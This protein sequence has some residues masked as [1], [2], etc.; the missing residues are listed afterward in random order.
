MDS[1]IVSSTII[2]GQ[3]GGIF[4]VQVAEELQREFSRVFV[5]KT[6]NEVDA[7][8]GEKV[9]Q[10]ASHLEDEVFKTAVSK[11]VVDGQT[12]SDS[13]GLANALK[14][15]VWETIKIPC[16]DAVTGATVNGDDVPKEGDI[17]RFENIAKASDVETLSQKVSTNKQN[18]DSITTEVEAVKNQTATNTSDIEG[19]QQTLTN[20]EHFRGYY[21]T[22]LEV[23]AIANPAEGDFS[24]NAETGTKWVFNGT[25][26]ND[27]AIPVPDQTTPLSDLTPL[28]DGTAGVGIA[29][30]AARGDHRH[31]TDTTRASVADLASYLPL[32]GG[33]L[34]G[35][36]TATEFTKT[37]SSNSYVLLGG[38]DHKPLSEFNAAGAHL[39]LA[40]G[41]I[42]GD[43]QVQGKTRVNAPLIIDATNT[44]T[45]DYDQGIRIIKSATNWATIL[46]GAPNADFG[47][48]IDGWTIAR[49]DQ[50]RFAIGQNNDAAGSLGLQITTNNNFGLGGFNDAYKLYVN[51][52]T[53]ITENIHMNGGI[54]AEGGYHS[55]NKGFSAGDAPRDIYGYF[56][57]T[58]LQ[59]IN[60]ATCFSW[61]RQGSAA[62]ALGH[63]T[64]NQIV[65][66]G[67]NF[68]KTVAPWL[69]IANYG[70]FQGSD[71]R[72]KTDIEKVDTS[73]AKNI[74]FK[75]YLKDGRKE[76]GVI[77]QEVL[78]HMPEAVTV[79]ED[80][81]DMMTVNYI[82]ILSAKC[83]Q[84]EQEIKELKQLVG[85]LK[86]LIIR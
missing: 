48:P 43:L 44:P 13:V 51:G 86:Q 41:T 53:F 74:E 68:D 7:T 72:M 32:S 16:D 46:L 22:T 60:N 39:P 38:G 30:S 52:S 70:I 14:T 49:T 83:A 63:N 85:E 47:P 61:V 19:L 29:T 56:N 54:E 6:L 81:E 23:K 45:N 31:P 57:V 65:I 8:T 58:R 75:Q 21:A 9:V 55:N 26:W 36:L 17:L 37:N 2:D 27:T 50:G 11:W 1:I 82:H 40:G 67:G 4:T 78:P 71:A 84:Y 25:T 34:T 80:P 18:I 33:T 10:I 69:T 12:F 20:K 77:A 76:I 66:G 35:A 28:A 42:T 59:S 62:F 5:V 15:I 79:P 64:S 73:A 3:R 24:Y